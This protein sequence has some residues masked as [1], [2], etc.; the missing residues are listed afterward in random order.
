MA[1][2]TVNSQLT[3]RELSN[4]LAPGDKTLADIIEVMTEQN[5]MLLDIPWFQ[6][7]QILSE[8]FPRR[9]SLP[10]GTFRK[11][12]KGVPTTA[13]TTE[14]VVE[15]VALLEALSD[16]DEDEVD[17][18]P[19]PIGYRRQEDIAFTEGLSQ[20]LADA[21]LESQ[22]AGSPEKFD[23]LKIRLNAL[24]QTNVIDG[25]NSGGTS[26]YIVNWGRRRTHGIYPAASMNRGILGL[27]MIDKDKVDKLDSGGTDIYHVYRT[28]F[29]WW[30]GLVVKDELTI[31]RYANINPT[32]KGTN[33]FNE[34]L[35]I[36]LL[37]RCHMKGP[38][39]RMYVNDEIK[40]QMEIRLKDK[41]NVN[42]SF[43]TGLSGEEVLRFGNRAI[44]RQLDAIKTDESTVG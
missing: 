40:T 11:A 9:T 38:N 12:Y 15:P 29:K 14:P 35:L 13:S 33:S 36:E 3:F 31:A 23:G 19:D 30:V 5:E 26:I 6:A 34:D 17:N 2:K 44:I 25:S 28:Q 10:T 16:I 20:Q 42:F 21:Y 27:Q 7:N 41:G 32:I 39:V 22:Q 4:R 43:A 8:K 24:T 1:T 37:N 18:T